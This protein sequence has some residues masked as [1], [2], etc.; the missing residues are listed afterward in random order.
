MHRLETAV[1]FPHAHETDNI[2]KHVARL[3]KARVYMLRA[4]LVTLQACAA[5]G[6]T[7]RRIVST[8]PNLKNFSFIFV[9]CTEN[10]RFKLCED[11]FYFMSV[12]IEGRML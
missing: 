10:I 1:P 12:S 11:G 5:C 4:R 8:A 9:V 6:I 3:C 7:V 2:T